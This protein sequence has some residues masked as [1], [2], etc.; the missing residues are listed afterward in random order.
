MK[1]DSS[2]LIHFEIV[3]SLCKCTAQH[4]DTLYAVEVVT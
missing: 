3:I 4:V 2:F 1:K